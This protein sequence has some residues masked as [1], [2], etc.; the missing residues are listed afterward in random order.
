MKNQAK[1]TKGA[2]SKGVE[3]AVSKGVVVSKGVK[4]DAILRAWGRR[5]KK[6]VY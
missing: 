1:T 2:V 5:L 4:H 6:A 3:G